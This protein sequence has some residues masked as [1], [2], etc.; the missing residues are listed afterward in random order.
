M[1]HLHYHIQIGFVFCYRLLLADHFVGSQHS[2]VY[3]RR[4]IGSITKHSF[5]LLVG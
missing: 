1:I 5:S 2:E 4:G 3:M